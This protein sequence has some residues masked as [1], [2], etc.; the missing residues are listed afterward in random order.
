MES[1]L[2]ASAPKPS[3]TPPL[4]A[5]VFAPTAVLKFPSLSS[6]PASALYPI[7]SDPK[8]LDLAEPPITIAP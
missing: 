8:F 3:A 4:G 1:L 5:L 7:E 6:N 2:N